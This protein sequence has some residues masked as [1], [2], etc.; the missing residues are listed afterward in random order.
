MRRFRLKLLFVGITVLGLMVTTALPAQAASLINS[1]PR[2]IK[3]AS[4]LQSQVWHIQIWGTGSSTGCYIFGRSV[5]DTYKGSGYAFDYLNSVY[6]RNE[7][8]GATSSG[9]PASGE[10][11]IAIKTGNIF[12]RGVSYDV[13]YVRGTAQVYWSTDGALGPTGVLDNRV[14]VSCFPTSSATGKRTFT[15]RIQRVQPDDTNHSS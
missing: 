15:P 1:K 13:F 10:P 5:M 2:T 8:T 4:G 14:G 3:S 9:S 11:P 6:L 7:D 12:M